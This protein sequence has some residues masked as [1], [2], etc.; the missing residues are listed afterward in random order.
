LDVVQ[1]S[2]DAVPVTTTVLASIRIALGD[3]AVVGPGEAICENLVDA[4]TAP[5]RWAG[6]VSIDVKR[7]QKKRNM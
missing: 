1:P 4:A 7:C 2:D 6:S 5:L 3:Q